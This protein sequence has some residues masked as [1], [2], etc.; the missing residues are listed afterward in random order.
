M[1]SLFSRLRKAKLSK[2]NVRNFRVLII[3]S[4]LNLSF[5]IEKLLLIFGIDSSSMVVWLRIR[6]FL[7][8]TTI[9]RMSWKRMNRGIRTRTR[10]MFYRRFRANQD[11][12]SD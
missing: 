11:S 1:S 6:P 3:A 7:P 2:D 5:A 9:S 12:I 10:T 4:I 8:S